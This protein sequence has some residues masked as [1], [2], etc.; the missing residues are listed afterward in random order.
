MERCIEPQSTSREKTTNLVSI[1]E[2][3]QLL[4]PQTEHG[5][6]YSLVMCEWREAPLSTPASPPTAPLSPPLPFQMFP[7]GF[8]FHS[9]PASPKFLVSCS[10][11]SPSL[12]P[13]SLER[14]SPQ[15]IF[16]SSS[17]FNTSF[18]AGALDLQLRPCHA[19]YPGVIPLRPITSIKQKLWSWLDS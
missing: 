19:I 13:F 14:L 2:G 3:K 4:L 15:L 1:S 6:R 11:L 16:P 18:R 7:S 17:L 9:V 12:V 10:V 8:L 5:Y